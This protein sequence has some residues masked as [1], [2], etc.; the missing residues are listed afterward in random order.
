MFSAI[1]SSNNP[2]I[3]HIVKLRESRT[4]RREGLFLIDGIREVER[5]WRSGYEFA[6]VFWNAGEDVRTDGHVDL[7]SSLKNVCPDFERRDMLK[8]L[9]TLTDSARVP[10]IPLSSGV[11]AKIGF[12][13]RNEGVLAV[14]K[15]KL[16]TLGEL[17]SYLRKKSQTVGEAPL[18]GVVEGVEKPGNIGAIFRSADG[19]GVDAL[20]IAA[21]DYDVYNP[22]SIRGSLG[23]IFHV[24]VVVA[25]TV[26]ILD[27]LR[28]RN[29]QRATALCDEAI[30]Y[31]QLDYRL[32]TA[33]VLGSESEGLSKEWSLESQIDFENNL[34]RKIRLPMLGIADSLNVSNAAAI[35]FYEARRVRSYWTPGSESV[36]M[37]ATDCNKCSLDSSEKGC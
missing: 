8:S 16:T 26:T 2:R 28:K 29:I 35:L 17:D 30:P 25:P 24:P 18:L 6:E 34:L 5:A 32:P 23:A 33:I 19:A 20:M 15:S 9:L 27:W 31:A 4:R 22:N 12:G 14:V 3:K 13:E 1:V 7:D 21:E 10:T 36:G 11:F 37:L